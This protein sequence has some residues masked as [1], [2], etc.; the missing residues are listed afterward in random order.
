MY[1]YMNMYMYNVYCICIGGLQLLL[2]G[3]ALLG[4]ELLAGAAGLSCI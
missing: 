4:S 3:G 1:T 2:E